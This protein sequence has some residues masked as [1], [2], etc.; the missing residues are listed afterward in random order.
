MHARGAKIIIMPQI[1][2]GDES[3]AVEDLPQEVIDALPDDIREEIISG[4]RDQIPEDVVEQL[5]PDIADRIPDGLVDTAGANPTLTA[6]V[7][8]IALLSVGGAIMGAIKGFIKVAIFLG[9]I[10][11]A[12]WFFVLGG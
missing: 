11:A 7:V 5:T 3:I 2:Q 6:V 4:A 9:L 12:A 8:V 1:A 10:A